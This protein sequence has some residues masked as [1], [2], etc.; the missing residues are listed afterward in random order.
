MARPLQAETISCQP[1]KAIARWPCAE[2]LDHADGS[3]LHLFALFF[4]HFQLRKVIRS[5]F[6]DIEED[7]FAD[8]GS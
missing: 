5:V 2:Q 6:V 7:V 4:G 8:T 1:K 3:V